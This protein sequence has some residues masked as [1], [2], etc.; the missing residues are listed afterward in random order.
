MIP[1]LGCE[2]ARQLLEPLVDGELSMPE[3]VAVQAHLRSCAV[4]AARVEDLSLIGW[5]IRMGIPALQPHADDGRAL[6]VVQSGVLTR[7]R[8]ERSQ[9]LGARVS[10]MFTDMRLLWPAIGATMAVIVCLC[11]VVNVWHLTMQKGPNSLAAMLEAMANRGSDSHPMPLNAGMSVPRA[12]DE[13]VVVGGLLEN[14]ALMT[15]VV[16]TSGRVTRAELRTVSGSQE[17]TTYERAVLNAL[18]EQRFEPAQGRNGRR[19]AVEAVLYFTQV[20]A[21]PARLLDVPVAL[22]RSIQ[23]DSKTAPPAVPSGVQSS[24]ELFSTAA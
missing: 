22:P 17:P 18:R 12:L 23:S 19:V 10:E 6:A 21:V 13:G 1:A 20:T 4:C 2:T 3:Q 16:G 5:S 11:G 9:A 24:L 15:I 7:I 14:D 8:A